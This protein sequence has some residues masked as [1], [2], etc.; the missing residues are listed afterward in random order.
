MLYPSI[1][2]LRE[3]VDSKY[4]LVILAAKRSRDLI[5]GKMP[6]V[7]IGFS[8]PVSIATQEIAE[9]IISYTRPEESEAEEIEEAAAEAEGADADGEE[10]G[11]EEEQAAEDGEE[12]V[13]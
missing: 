11:A 1:N 13:L 4:T 2:D 9:D 12:D 5:D 6:L 7:D 8:K 3:K 10:I